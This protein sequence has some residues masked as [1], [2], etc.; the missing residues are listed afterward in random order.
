MPARSPV[1]RLTDIVEVIERV[2]ERLANITLDT[3]EADWESKWLVERGV[4]IISEASRH[5][6]S[7]LKDRHPE[8]PW[9]KIAGI[10]NILRHDYENVAAPILWVLVKESLSPLDAICRTELAVLQDGPPLHLDQ[11][12]PCSRSAPRKE[13]PL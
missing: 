6:P 10:G 9:R 4:E 7:E 13:S 5:L 1:A 12:R 11:T 3:F 2:R 8:I